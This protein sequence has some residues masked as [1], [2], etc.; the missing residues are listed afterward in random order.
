MKKEELEAILG[1]GRNDLDL[2]PIEAYLDALA[3]EPQLPR[4]AI[5]QC[6]IRIEESAPAMLAVL[7]R[8]ADGRPLSQEGETL[9]FRGLHILGAARNTQACRPLLQLLR[10][11]ADELDRLLGD[12][13]TE[14]L[15]RIVAGVFDGDAEALFDRIV[16]RSIDHFIRD[17]LLRATTFLTWKGLIE[18][19]RMRRFLVEFH[20]KRLAADE[21]EVWTGWLQAIALL[22]LRDLAPLVRGARDEGRVPPDTLTRSDFE[23]DLLAAEQRPDDIE[24]FSDIDLG[25]IE[26]AIEAL[27][28]TDYVDDEDQDGLFDEANPPG[29]DLFKQDYSPMEPVRNPLRYV[30]RNDPCPCGSGKKAKRCCLA[31][32]D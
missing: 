26:D 30:G 25:Y 15:A 19:E 16:D 3:S 21:D 22:G 32:P 13:V 1:D 5:A 9:L 20:Q 2:G 17:A 18:R 12:A 7:E 31:R 23:Q 28:W 6:T 27:E 29:E 24:R 4:Y 8:A 10:R 11:P 14:G